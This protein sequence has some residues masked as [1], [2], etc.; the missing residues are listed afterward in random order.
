MK[1]QAIEQAQAEAAEK[2]RK[3]GDPSGRA[4]ARERSQRKSKNH[5]RRLEQLL[6]AEKPQ[7]SR[8]EVKEETAVTLALAE[9][10]S[11]YTSMPE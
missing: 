4:K 6:G 10:I 2:K 3:Q 11:W 5:R 7:E 1:Q 8:Q 9:G